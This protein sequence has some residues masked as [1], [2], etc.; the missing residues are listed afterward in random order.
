[1]MLDGLCPLTTGLALDRA[2][3]IVPTNEALVTGDS[4]ITFDELRTAVDETAG[5]LLASGVDKGDHVAICLGNGIPWATLFLAITS[6]GAVAVPVNTRFQ[7]AELEYVLRQSKSRMLFVADKFLK[8]DFIAMLRQVLPAMDDRCGNAREGALP[9]LER[10]VV[11]GDDIPAAAEGFADFLQAGSAR[12]SPRGASPDDVALIQYTSGTTAF[13]KGV[14]LTHRSLCADAFFSGGRM[15]LRVGDRYHSARPFFH[16]AGTTLSLLSSLQHAATLITMDRFEPGAALTQMEVE[17]CTHFSGND[18]MALMLLGHPSLSARRLNL[19]GAWLAAS[20]AIVA[21][22]IDDLGA[23]EAV[24]GYGLS[25]AAP[26]VA[27]SAWWEPRELRVGG[28][29][30]PEP[31]VRVRIVDPDGGDC[32]AGMVGEIL[33]SGWNVMRGYYA[34][35]EQTAAALDVDGWLH[36]GDLGVLD[37][38]GRLRFVGRAK[39]IIRVGGENVSPAEVEDVLHSHPDIKQAVVVGV[40]D[41]RLVEVPFAFV[42]V[43][44]GAE[45][46][47]QTVIA[48]S[49]NMMAG[50]KVPR[51]VMFVD[52]FEEIGMTASGKVQKTA[53]ARVA[54]DHLSGSSR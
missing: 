41:E 46:D 16:V 34:M 42:A 4:R 29:M 19:R 18:T 28:W 20:P 2:S 10:I 52:D 45:L 3:A 14:L 48:W 23:T 50:F 49:K 1:M 5:A 13:P 43:G 47:E 38:D 22:V 6:I 33:V 17:S 26:N 53:A 54:N 37:A 44:N 31:G 9:D 39:E 32:P 15:G 11:L 8:V 27:Q 21:R 36:T 30:A 25:E 12:T 24:V 7:A 51:H 35:P 40:A